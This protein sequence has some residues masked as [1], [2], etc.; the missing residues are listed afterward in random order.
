MEPIVLSGLVGAIVG[1]TTA[2]VAQF[3]GHHLATKRDIFAPVRGR[4][5]EVSEV[6]EF[7]FALVADFKTITVLDYGRNLVPDNDRIK[8]PIHADRFRGGAILLCCL[9]VEP[10]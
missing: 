4:F 3:L 10:S 5:V 1:A 7:V 6:M 2:I 8:R 9:H